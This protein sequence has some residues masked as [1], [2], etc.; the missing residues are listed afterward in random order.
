MK[1]RNKQK[2]RDIRIADWQ[3]TYDRI[4][5]LHGE[6]RARGYHRPGSWK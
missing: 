2:R 6:S 3:R 1:Q 5:K 4:E